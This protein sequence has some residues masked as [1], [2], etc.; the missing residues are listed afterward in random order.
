MK[1]WEDFYNEGYKSK[2]Q[3]AR[4]AV[5]RYDYVK[6]LIHMPERYETKVQVMSNCFLNTARIRDDS[7][8]CIVALQSIIRVDGGEGWPLCAMSKRTSFMEKAEC[9]FALSIGEFY[10]SDVSVRKGE[11]GEDIEPFDVPVVFG[12]YAR[13]GKH[14]SLSR[15]EARQFI[16]DKIRNIL[17]L[18]HK[19][20][21][22]EIVIASK[23]EWLPA[24]EVAVLFREALYETGDAA[25]AF[26]KVTFALP[27]NE[28]PAAIYWGFKEEFKW[29]P[30]NQ[31]A[32]FKPESLAPEVSNLWPQ[33]RRLVARD[34]SHVDVQREDAGILES[35]ESNGSEAAGDASTRTS[36]KEEGAGQ[37][38][39]SSSGAAINPE[40]ALCLEASFRDVKCDG[41][42]NVLDQFRSTKAEMGKPLVFCE[43]QHWFYSSC[44]R[45][46]LAAFP[47]LCLSAEKFSDGAGIH[48]WSE[49]ERDQ[50]LQI[51]ETSL[52]ENASGFSIFLKDYPDMHL[53]ISVSAGSGVKL[54]KKM[55][56]TA[57]ALWEWGL[58]VESS[59]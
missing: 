8:L 22:E 3:P 43:F 58:P 25:G 20:G 46:K 42:A 34:R 26:R 10:V 5:A 41:T 52:L 56:G 53:S 45:I 59:I 36:T 51:W 24:R 1:C 33:G 11:L 29:T 35:V 13:P 55:T 30:T 37:A 7:N 39:G 19:H 50:H 44:G 31:E 18:C 49:V 6:Q 40:A 21:H 2:A 12:S 28:V 32:E 15:A 17:L 9:Q 48:L 27:F 38:A 14:V 57:I 23:F 16:R 47:E 4:K 54:I